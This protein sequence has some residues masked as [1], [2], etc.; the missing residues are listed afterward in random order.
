MLGFLTVFGVAPLLGCAVPSLC[1]VVLL[2]LV[3]P[4]YMQLLVVLVAVS[5]IPASWWGTIC[6]KVK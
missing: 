2:H 5:L 4:V 6:G 1:N 3:V